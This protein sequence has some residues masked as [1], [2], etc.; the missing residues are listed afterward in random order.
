MTAIRT[1]F[2]A[3]HRAPTYRQIH[4]SSYT[5]SDLQRSFARAKLAGLPFEPPPPP[6]HLVEN[7]ED[8]EIDDLKPLPE[9]PDDDSSSASSASSASSTGTIRPS[10]S[11][12]LFA[13]PKGFVK[14]TTFNTVYVLSECLSYSLICN[15]GIYGFSNAKPPAT[16]HMAKD[17]SKRKLYS[18]GSPIERAQNH[19]LGT[20]TS[21]ESYI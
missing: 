13:R 5:M 10:P 9:A 3:R 20:T 2:Y 16:F 21:L 14:S 1:F 19:F 15:I 6:N 8:D 11:K 4:L 7:E 17:N 18:A 12:H